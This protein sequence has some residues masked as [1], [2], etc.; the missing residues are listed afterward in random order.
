[1]FLSRGKKI[2]YKN[3]A[4]TLN[5]SENALPCFGPSH[6]FSRPK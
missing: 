3:L 6:H 2:V 4:G 5:K 1:M